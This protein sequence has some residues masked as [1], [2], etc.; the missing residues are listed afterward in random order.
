MTL[1]KHEADQVMSNELDVCIL[2]L[3]ESNAVHFKL[4][5]F[6]LFAFGDC[7]HPPKPW[8]YTDCTLR[9]VK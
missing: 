5:Y 2:L 3:G 6:L 8:L 9:N 7:L 1:C 4:E